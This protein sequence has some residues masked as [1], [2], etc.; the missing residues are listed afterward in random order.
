MHEVVAFFGEMSLIVYRKE[1]ESELEQDWQAMQPWSS[2]SS[3]DEADWLLYESM[4][5]QPEEEADNAGSGRSSVRKRRVRMRRKVPYVPRLLRNDIRRHYSQMMANTFNS[6][7]LSVLQS[8]FATYCT[9]VLTMQ[10]DPMAPSFLE[11]ALLEQHVDITPVN[12]QHH[13][14]LFASPRGLL[15]MM[16]VMMQLTPDHT[17]S[18]ESSTITTRSDTDETVIHMDFCGTFTHIY[19]VD[20]D[21]MAEEMAAAAYGIRMKN[22][23][24]QQ[25]CLYLPP[26]EPDATSTDHENRP[27]QDALGDMVSEVAAASA[28][29]SS[30]L[31]PSLSHSQLDSAEAPCSTY[32]SSDTSS[33][34]S[35][36]SSTVATPGVV[37]LRSRVKQVGSVRPPDAFTF[38]YLTRGRSVPLVPS[39]QR[40]SVRSRIVL[41]VNAERQI[42]LMESGY[43]C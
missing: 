21:N 16:A 17:M 19:D 9:S 31:P 26:I 14:L 18:L 3:T 23:P 12:R 33:P 30:T 2:G 35:S 39:P 11:R 6:H 10:R 8:F 29:P 28:I 4:E 15:L 37:G 22:E 27:I 40:F 34:P 13:Q 25:T 1:N 32:P 43:F 7:D 36:S 42:S 41:H 5:S 24:Q 38:Y 20:P